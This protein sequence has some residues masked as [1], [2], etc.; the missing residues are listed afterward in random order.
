MSAPDPEC[1]HCG[2][3]G[4][5]EAE[6]H[7]PHPPIFDRCK[8]VLYGDVRMNVERGMQG[9]WG[10]ARLQMSPLLGREEDNLWITSGQEFLS[11]LRYVAVRQSPT[12]MFK[13]VSDAELTTA[14]LASIAVQGR[15]ILD[16]DAY[17]VS[18]RALTIP[19]LVLPPDLLII[20]MGIKVTRN[21]AASE[22]LGEALNLRSH[23]GRATWLWDEPH[24]PLDVGHLFWSDRV[25]LILRPWE[26]LDNLDSPS[27]GGSVK[28]SSSL[29][30]TRGRKTLRGGRKTLRGGQDK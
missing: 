22:C 20:R 29:S 19:D 17:K 23:E 24:A 26:H 7:P 14:W 1:P 13:V 25:A 16:A 12:W 6:P 15:D 10:Q 9:L 8:C 3:T 11:H 27:G 30:S 18:T 21:S 28:K 4:M 5:V 2:G